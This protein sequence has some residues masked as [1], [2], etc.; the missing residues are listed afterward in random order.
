MER[1]SEEMSM[2]VGKNGFF[3]VGLLDEEIVHGTTDKVSLSD[4]V[5]FSSVIR[6][7]LCQLSVEFY[8]L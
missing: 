7:Y 5:S 3:E 6:L 1:D 8:L 4:R 2:C